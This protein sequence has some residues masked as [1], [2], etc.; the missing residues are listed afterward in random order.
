MDAHRLEFPDATF[1]VVTLPFVLTLV[2]GPE[3]VLSEGA[4]VTKPEEAF[5]VANRISRGEI[6]LSTL[7]RA[8]EPVARRLGLSGSFHLSTIEQWSEAHGGVPIDAVEGLR[9]VGFFKLMV[10][11][12]KPS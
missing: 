3:V 12:R 6:L 4:R 10:I 9:P 5:I 7:E 2:A 8:I 11:Y 1:D